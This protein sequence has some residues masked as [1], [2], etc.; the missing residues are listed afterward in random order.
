MTKQARVTIVS[1]SGMGATGTSTLRKKLARKL[2][3]PSHSGGDS[4]RAIMAADDAAG[5]SPAVYAAKHPG[6]DAKIERWNRR[7]VWKHRKTGGVIEA[8]LALKATKG[9]RCARNILLVCDDE[10]RF[11]RERDR[12][13]KRGE[14]CTLER[15]RRD[16]LTRD[17]KDRRRFRELY[18]IKD[19]TN[20]KLYDLVIDT[21][22]CNA[23]SCVRRII[24]FLAEL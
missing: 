10:I 3:L 7:F 16:I 9:L 24:K 19:I 4:L 2:K 1:L 8:R 18:G 17:R 12:R 21:G 14:R 13:R 22:K 23:R 6:L 11:R 15:A 20:P 5:M